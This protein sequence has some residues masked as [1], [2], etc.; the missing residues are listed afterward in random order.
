LQAATELTH[1][2]TS[3]WHLVFIHM[4]APGSSDIRLATETL[5]RSL[6]LGS[7]QALLV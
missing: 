4:G 1:L 3:P 6:V 2:D 5:T 7:M